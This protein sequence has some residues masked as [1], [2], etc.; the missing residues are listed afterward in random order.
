M[1]LPD[2]LERVQQLTG[3]PASAIEMLG[4]PVLNGQIALNETAVRYDVQMRP[5]EARL[6]GANGQCVSITNIAVDE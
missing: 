5:G 3:A 6:Y 2:E 1:S 4:N